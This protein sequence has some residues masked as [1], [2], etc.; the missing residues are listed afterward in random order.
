MSILLIHKGNQ[1]IERFKMIQDFSISDDSKL[2]EPKGRG[3]G[4]QTI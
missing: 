3:G 4:G 1:I 2:L